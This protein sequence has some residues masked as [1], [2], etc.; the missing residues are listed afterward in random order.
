MNSARAPRGATAHEV[1]PILGALVYVL[2]SYWDPPV[3]LYVQ[4][5]PDRAWA[6]RA[7]QSVEDVQLGQ[8]PDAEASHRT[9]EAHR[10]LNQQ[11]LLA[12]QYGPVD[13]E[14][15]PGI[16][17]PFLRKSAPV[18]YCT[19]S[20]VCSVVESEVQNCRVWCSLLWIFSWISGL[21]ICQASIPFRA[22][23]KPEASAIPNRACSRTQ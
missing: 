9:S 16:S 14:Y 21:L 1:A 23:T 2:N 11:Q 10:S 8:K 22:K 4:R 17:S 18:Q 5:Q 6:S 3:R 13:I 12:V 19:H 15:L 20:P 7:G